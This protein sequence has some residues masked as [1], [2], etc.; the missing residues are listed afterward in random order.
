MFPPTHIPTL[1]FAYV[2]LLVWTCF[3]N[4][5]SPFLSS[6]HFLCLINLIILQDS[7]LTVPLASLTLPDLEL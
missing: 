3:S 5:L 7:T 1:A 4:G 2:A 6:L